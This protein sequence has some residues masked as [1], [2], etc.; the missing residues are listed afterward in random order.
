MFGSIHFLA[1]YG[2]IGSFFF[3]SFDFL[4]FQLP[5]QFPSV[6]LEKLA[7]DIV[8]SNILAS[9]SGLSLIYTPAVSAVA[10]LAAPAATPWLPRPTTAITMIE[11]AATRIQMPMR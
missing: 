5:E 9:A 3:E 10:L 1:L 11:M 7:K 6:Q 4:Y 8:Q 2:F